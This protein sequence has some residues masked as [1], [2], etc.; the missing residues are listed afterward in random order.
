[1][2]KRKMPR[3]K[4][5]YREPKKQKEEVKTFDSPQK[6]KHF[7]EKK[8]KKTTC[9]SP[10]NIKLKPK[11]DPKSPAKPLGCSHILCKV[12]CQKEEFSRTIIRGLSED[13]YLSPN[14]CRVHY[15][16]PLKAACRSGNS[17]LLVFLHAKGLGPD[18]A[19]AGDNIGL[20]WACENGHA[21]ILRDLKNLFGLEAKDAR[22]RNNMALC[23]ACKHDNVA[24]VNELRNSFCLD[25]EDARSRDHTCLMMACRNKSAE[26]IRALKDF[27]L[28][29]YDAKI[30]HERMSKK[31]GASAY[32][33]ILE[34]LASTF[35]MK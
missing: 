9:S 32:K 31:Y 10:R 5:T 11:D 35:G 2:T 7:V 6:Y 20:I 4:M 23:F 30:V 1:M 24:V 3:F 14:D 29:E 12:A 16:M 34:V 26:M 22:T 18:D 25:A 8:I 33:E 27:G 28:D 15:N 21:R 17:D 13:I 19:R